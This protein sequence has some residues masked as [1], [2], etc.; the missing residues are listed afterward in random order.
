MYVL[1]CQIVVDGKADWLYPEDIQ[2]IL[3]GLDLKKEE[4]RNLQGEFCQAGMPYSYERLQR[5]CDNIRSLQI[6]FN[7]CLE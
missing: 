1:C 6:L 7:G 4:L 3:D 2:Y 5:E